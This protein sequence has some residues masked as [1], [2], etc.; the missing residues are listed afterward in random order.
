MYAQCKIIL[1]PNSYR[2]EMINSLLGSR[3]WLLVCFAWVVK[4]D[5]HTR[6]VIVA[7]NLI[8]FISRFFRL[9]IKKNS[10]LRCHKKELKFGNKRERPTHIVVLGTNTCINS[11]SEMCLFTC[12]KHQIW[13]MTLVFLEHFQMIQQFR[14]PRNI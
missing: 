8:N 2:L 1:E 14:F 5:N 6:L 7:L 10:S 11:K 12:K 9:K 13:T 4:F 3:D